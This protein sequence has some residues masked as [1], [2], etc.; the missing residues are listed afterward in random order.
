MADRETPGFGTAT[1]GNGSRRAED[2]TLHRARD[3]AARS[4]RGAMG[5][6]KGRVRAL[7]DQQTNRA[8]DQL[9][10]VAHALHTAADQLDQENNANAAHY[11]AR[12]ADRVEE[13]ADLVRHADVDE[14][15]HRVER[16]AHRQ[17]EVFIGAAFATGFLF[18]RF[19]KSSGDRREARRSYAGAPAG[20]PGDRHYE[21]PDMARP[22]IAGAYPPAGAG[23]EYHTPDA[24][25]AARP[26]SPDLGLSPSASGS[27]HAGTAPRPVPPMPAATP[28]PTS[29]PTAAPSSAPPG[30]RP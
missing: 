26:G 14:V 4:G 29:T 24:N 1:G 6:A 28:A 18:A 12:A 19:I 10:G 27:A 13:V 5:A 22:D 3:E 17:P 16:F 15:L 21:A 9:S 11:A 7:F 20:Y 2:D 25:P 8:A 23:G 30:P